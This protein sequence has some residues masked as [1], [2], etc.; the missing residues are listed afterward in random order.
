MTQQIRNIVIVG[1]GTAGW[2]TAAY[3]NH[4]LQW[5]V[6]APDGIK[7]T[8]IESPD[9]PTIGVGEATVPTLKGTLRQLQISE[10]E[11]ILRTDATFKLGIRLEGWNVGPGG[12]PLAFTNP[13]TAG[14]SSYGRNPAYS[15]L[16]YARAAGEHTSGDSFGR[17]MGPV[18]AAIEACKGP[19]Q[20]DERDFAGAL[21][22]AYHVD[23][24]KLADFFKELC[25]ARGVTHLADTVRGWTKD[26]RG[27]IATLELAEH[28]AEPVDLVIDCTGFRGLLIN[29]AM[30]EPF[31]SYADYL[32]NDRA[33]PI[34]VAQP[35]SDRI[36]P[37][38]ISRAL[39][40]GWSW[41]IP[42]HS[43]V[44]TG[45]AYSSAFASDSAAEDELRGLLAGQTAI[46]QPRVLKMRVGKT[47][48]S[49]VGN[50]VAIGA[51]AG[52]MEPLE[53]TTIL[54]IELAARRLARFFPSMA[55]EQ[56]LIDR[57]NAA[58]DRTYAEVLD[59][60]S[61]HFTLSDREDTPYWR[62]V[63]HEAKRSD[64]LNEDMAAWRHV[65]PSSEDGRAYE[66]FSPLSVALVLIGK[67]FYEGVA[68]P[69]ADIVPADLWNFFRAERAARLN[70]T[71][72]DLPSHLELIET[73]RAR[74]VIGASARTPARQIQD[75]LQADDD[76]R[77]VLLRDTEAL[78]RQALRRPSQ[79]IAT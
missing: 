53:S 65:L 26:K 36:A 15:F 44:G 45:Y 23:A 75:A 5:G 32:F 13:F 37:V 50:C 43:R 28:G 63:R 33:V 31:E 18:D 64:A 55:M 67:G 7:L 41:R 62:A 20:P 30:G 14:A 73:I 40:S 68:L 60:L 48:R 78:D 69:Q 38:T 3:L 59:F 66:V 35:E 52:F 4:R 42:L 2:I 29:E 61:L 6:T 49:W 19:R 16:Q 51:S 11:F 27:R 22:Y 76:Q 8:V 58:M 77:S 72:A 56:P 21:Q 10:D 9:I 12:S 1:G 74:A 24:G 39:G 25:I 47:R 70:R 71:V 79:I 54:S 57:F 46:T 34:Q 17:L